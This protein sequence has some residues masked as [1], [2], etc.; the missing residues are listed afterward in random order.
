MKKLYVLVLLACA[1]VGVNVAFACEDDGCSDGYTEW[2]KGGFEVSAG[3]RVYGD[4]ENMVFNLTE[5]EV[6]ADYGDDKFKFKGG[7][8]AMS[9]GTGTLDVG[10]HGW[11]NWDAWK[12]GQCLVGCDN[13]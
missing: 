13:K 11:G 1:L 9:E 3:T 10:G 5:Y 12:Q 4:G 8:G 7:W 6:T 2:R